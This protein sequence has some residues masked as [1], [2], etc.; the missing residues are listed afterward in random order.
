MREATRQQQGSKETET[1]ELT[2]REHLRLRREAAALDENI[3]L[4]ANDPSF[5]VKVI[6]DDKGGIGEISVYKS[7]ALMYY[8]N[9]GAVEKWRKRRT[10]YIN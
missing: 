7:G 1:P 10:E 3:H 4:I 8:K 6:K 5:N 9:F 2:Q